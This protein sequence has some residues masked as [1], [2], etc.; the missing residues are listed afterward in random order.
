MHNIRIIVKAAANVILNDLTLNNV[1][2]IATATFRICP[3]S[4]YCCNIDCSCR[5]NVGNMYPLLNSATTNMQST[6]YIRIASDMIVHTADKT[7]V[8]ETIRKLPL[9]KAQTALK[10]KKYVLSNSESVQCNFSFLIT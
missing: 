2:L 9:V 10:N 3:S 6:H 5:I 1:E 8:S 4:G 7:S